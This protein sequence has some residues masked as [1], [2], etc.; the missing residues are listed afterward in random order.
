MK[1]EVGKYYKSRDGR[2]WKCVHE[3]K[4]CIDRSI[5]RFLMIP[6]DN[7]NAICKVHDDGKYYFC[8]AEADSDLISEWV[9]P[10]EHEFEVEFYKDEK[11]FVSLF[12]IHIH[13][14]NAEPIA[15]VKVKFTEGEGL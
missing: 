10:V 7:D 3:Y 8:G 15:K 5:P 4:K 9:E 12:D 2:K 11:G 13:G 14:L 1:L 6:D